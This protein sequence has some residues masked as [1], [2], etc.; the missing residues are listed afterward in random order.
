MA[1]LS[2]A[3]IMF[4]QPAHA[5]AVPASITCADPAGNINA[6][7]VQWNNENQYFSDKGNIAAHFCEG[8]YA[9]SYSTFVGVTT[10]SG[11][12]L[13]PALLY[14]NGVIPEPDLPVEPVQSTE[15]VERSTEDTTRIT[16]EVVRTEDVARTEEVVRQPDP[17]PQPAPVEPVAPIEPEPTPEPQPEVEPTPESPVSPVEPT[18]PP[19]VISPTPEPVQPPT[20]PTEPEI[21]PEPTI[22]P[23][24]DFSSALGAI[25]DAIAETFGQALEAL[26]TA[27]LDM[28]DE[29]RKTA[30]SV[31]V[32]SVI[33]A[34]IATLT[35][36]K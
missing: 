32:P 36:R 13:E 23:P 34:Q 20:S 19:E 4:A 21:S 25:G 7:A 3:P 12:E 16:E 33:V 8:G 17:E 9:G 11:D 31:I 29:E 24:Q 30:Q 15:D 35:F 28:T 6:W 26:Q 2:F 18:E 5:A 22:Q 14:Y 10:W 27:G 1:L